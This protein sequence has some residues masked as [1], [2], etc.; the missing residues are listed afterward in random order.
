[1]SN[2]LRYL[3]H[4]SNIFIKDLEKY[5]GIA[6]SSLSRFSTGDGFMNEHHIAVLASFFNVT[7]DFLIGMS[8]YGLRVFPESKDDPTTIDLEEYSRK[9]TRIRMSVVNMGEPVILKNWGAELKLGGYQLYRSF[10]DIGEEEINEKETI[11]QIDKKLI[12]LDESQ[13]S[14]VD[15]FIKEYILK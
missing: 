10:N 7:S 4:D 1:M 2:N 8:G 5:T 15:N 12:I 6:Y 11:E 13:L 14:K 3:L 9:R